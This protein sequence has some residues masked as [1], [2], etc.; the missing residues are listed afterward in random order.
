[1][2]RYTKRRVGVTSSGFVIHRIRIVHEKGKGGA[3]IA[4]QDIVSA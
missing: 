1:M 4:M 3:D 2:R